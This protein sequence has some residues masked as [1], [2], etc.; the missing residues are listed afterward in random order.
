[1]INVARRGYGKSILEA[2]DISA[3]SAGKAGAP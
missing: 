2:R 3:A 1:M